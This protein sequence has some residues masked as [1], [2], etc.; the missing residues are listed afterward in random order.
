MCPN[1]F[2]VLAAKSMSIVGRVTGAFQAVKRRAPFQNELVCER[3]VGQSIE[4]A[5]HG[6]V[7]Q[8]FLKR[9]AFCA[10]AVQ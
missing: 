2:L 3:G 6:E 1:S 9:P 10:G 5:L 4:E 7:L 8:E